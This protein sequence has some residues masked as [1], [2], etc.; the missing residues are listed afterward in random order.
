MPH[1]LFLGSS[2]AT[3]DRVFDDHFDTSSL[4]SSDSQSSLTPLSPPTS[5]T[6]PSFP[7]RVFSAI[8]SAH[9]SVVDSLRRNLAWNKLLD[10]DGCNDL[11]DC[12]HGYTNWENRGTRFVKA[13]LNH[14]IA[15]IVLSLLGFAVLINSM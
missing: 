6:T 15:D 7:T 2:L 10:K 3:Q 13:H 1:G 11:P 4:S 5:T 12:D 14:S 8:A 9:T